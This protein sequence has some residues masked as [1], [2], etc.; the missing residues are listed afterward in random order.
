MADSFYLHPGR[1]Y[2]SFEPC[3]VTTILGSCVAVCIWDHKLKIGGINHYLLPYSPSK[4]DALLKFGNVA[5]NYLMQ[6]IFAM[7]CTR[8]NLQ[9]K[10]FGGACVLEAF[11]HK[12]DHLGLKNV[13]IAIKYL[14]MEGI[15]I[16]ENDVGGNNGRK[17]IFQTNSGSALVKRL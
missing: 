1:L 5:I 10:I 7:G 8:G 13:E 6:K 2:T 9:A 11:K 12:D 15:P 17:I 4:G 16:I 14:T 3:A